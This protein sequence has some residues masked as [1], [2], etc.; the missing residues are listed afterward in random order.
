MPSTLPWLPASPQV[1]VDALTDGFIACMVAFGSER[2]HSRH[3]MLLLLH[4]AVAVVRPVL[5]GVLIHTDVHE[6]Y[7]VCPTDNG[8]FM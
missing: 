1:L 6:V 4:F 7:F 8:T 5:F 2:L 3:V